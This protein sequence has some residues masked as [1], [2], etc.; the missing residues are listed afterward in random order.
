MSTRQLVAE[1]IRKARQESGLTQKK[2]GFLIGMAGST[3]SLYETAE[4]TDDYH[5]AGCPGGRAHHSDRPAVNICNTD[6]P[7]VHAKRAPSQGAPSIRRHLWPR[8]RVVVVGS[9][10]A[11]AQH[12][13]GGRHPAPPLGEAP[14]ELLAGRGLAGGHFVAPSTQKKASTPPTSTSVAAPP[15]AS[16]PHQKS[17]VA[18]M[19]A[20]QCRKAI[21]KTITACG[22]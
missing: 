17:G 13:P 7:P 2:F 1:R 21:R 4:E 14:E 8:N 18:N 3:L 15:P 6:S 9:H 5:R 11:A 20:T 19:A 12:V 22:R 10:G 16:T